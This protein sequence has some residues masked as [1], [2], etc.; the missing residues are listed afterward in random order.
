MTIRIINK[1]EYICKRLEG[2]KYKN[3]ENQY[4]CGGCSYSQV[5]LCVVGGVYPN[6]D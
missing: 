4:K 6:N 5:V 1:T 3:P 2:C